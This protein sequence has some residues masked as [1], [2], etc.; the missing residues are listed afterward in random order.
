MLYEARSTMSPAGNADDVAN[1]VRE[2]RMAQNQTQEDLGQAI[3]LT[4]QSIIAIE[5][6]R[7]TPSIQTALRLA[8]ALGTSVDRLFWLTSGTDDGAHS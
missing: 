6:G 3:G 5:K 7:F 1:R 4:R 2:L 8:R